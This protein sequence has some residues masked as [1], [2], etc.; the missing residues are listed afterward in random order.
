MHKNVVLRW[1]DKQVEIQK[2][3]VQ[4]KYL[5]SY[6]AYI[7]NINFSYDNA[8]QITGLQ[9]LYDVLGDYIDFHICKWGNDGSTVMYIKYNDFIFYTFFDKVEKIKGKIKID[10]GVDFSE[11]LSR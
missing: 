2:M 7:C 5:E 6:D 3:V 11:V 1:L 8:I 10:E 4:N 9:Y